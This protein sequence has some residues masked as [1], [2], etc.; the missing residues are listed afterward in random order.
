[1]LTVKDILNEHIAMKLDRATRNDEP[2]NAA[3]RREFT[4]M[5][6]QEERD[7][8]RPIWVPTEYEAQFGDHIPQGR[9][10]ARSSRE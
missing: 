6:D 7:V 1:M 3:H 8:E 2:R 9:K 5:P 4:A 10:N